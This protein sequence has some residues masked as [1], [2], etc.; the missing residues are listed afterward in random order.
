MQHCVPGYGPGFDFELIFPVTF[1]LHDSYGMCPG[2]VITDLVSTDGLGDGLHLC[3][4]LK[5][6]RMLY[7]LL[8]AVSPWRPSVQEVLFLP[9]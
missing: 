1:Q 7:R 8:L 9:S 6:R 2:A 3:A 5:T 4:H